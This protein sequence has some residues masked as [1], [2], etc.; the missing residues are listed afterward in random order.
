MTTT[1]TKTTKAT[2]LTSRSDLLSLTKRRYKTVEISELGLTF[3]IQSLTEREKSEYETAL[4]TKTGRSVSRER[5]TDAARRLMVL[6]LVDDNGDRLLEPADVGSLSQL[7]AIV[8][9]KIYDECQSHCGFGDDD[10]EQ[11][12]KNSERVHVD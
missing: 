11:I 3:R 12:V 6:C 8:A 5:L 4:L 7:D 2:T 9:T 10:I 1:K